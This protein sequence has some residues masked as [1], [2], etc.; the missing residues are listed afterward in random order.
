M[1]TW[2]QVL[3]RDHT[4]K[5]TLYRDQMHKTGCKQ[6]KIISMDSKVHGLI[7]WS[8]KYMGSPRW[9]PK[10]KNCAYGPKCTKTM[11]S[12]RFIRSFL[13]YPAPAEF[14][15]CLPCRPT[16][17]VSTGPEPALRLP[18]SSAPA[19]SQIWSLWTSACRPRL[20]HLRTTRT[21]R[22]SLA[23]AACRRAQ[24]D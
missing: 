8:P 17:T 18:L 14:R 24:C 10:C 7:T 16:D 15:A 19:R 23:T 6:P 20:A 5:K 2:E 9:S 1:V 4:H 22:S 21:A 11:G 12:G 3:Y 13:P